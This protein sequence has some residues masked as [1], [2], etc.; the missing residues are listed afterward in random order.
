M[1]ETGRRNDDC[2]DLLQPKVLK[3]HAWIKAHESVQYARKLSRDWK[4]NLGFGSR[5]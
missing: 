3:D 5:N 2:Q 1:P 4:C